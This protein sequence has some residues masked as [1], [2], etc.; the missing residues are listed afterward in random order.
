[1]N[2]TITIVPLTVP[3]L[4]LGLLAWIGLA[5]VLGGI[6]SWLAER[7]RAD[8]RHL[9]VHRRWDRPGAHVTFQGGR[10]ARVCEVFFDSEA[11]GMAIVQP[12]HGEDDLF[13]PEWV[14]LGDLS[15]LPD[16]A[17]EGEDAGQAPDLDEDAA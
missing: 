13:Q 11:G 7:F 14:P 3:G 16:W 1:M 8:V 9:R 6:A 17:R 4:M 12:Y 15:P 2:I 5:A 10:R